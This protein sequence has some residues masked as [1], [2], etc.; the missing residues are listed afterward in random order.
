MPRG[1]RQS[2]T[3][4][5]RGDISTARHFI[6]AAP[7]RAS[8]SCCSPWRQEDIFMSSLRAFSIRAMTKVAMGCLAIL[9]LAFPTMAQRNSGEYILLLASGSLCDPS[10]SSSCPATVKADQGDSYEM[11]GAGTFDAQNKSVKVAGTF[12]HKSPNGNLLETGVWLASELVRF[13]SYGAAPGALPSKGGMFGRAP[14]ALKR[15]PMPPSSTPTGGLAVFRIRLLPTQGLSKDA[16]L[17]VNSALGD[18]P[19][20]RSVEGIRLALEKNG[21]EFSEEVSGRVMFLLMRPKVS[22]PDKTAQRGIAPASTET[23]SN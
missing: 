16:V 23:P 17:Q 8:H 9:L 11:S 20:E 5:S 13:D 19:S 1:L 4:N 14:F 2:Q 15:P 7:Y 10:D 3:S 18:V 12:T 6:S 21:P 22:A